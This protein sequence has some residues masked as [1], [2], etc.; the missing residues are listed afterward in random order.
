[1]KVVQSLRT[2]NFMYTP[3]IQEIFPDLDLGLHNSGINVLFA[4]PKRGRPS[5]ADIKKRKRQEMDMEYMPTNSSSKKSLRRR[6]PKRIKTG[7]GPVVDQSSSGSK[8]VLNMADIFLQARDLKTGKWK[9]LVEWDDWSLA[10]ASWTPLTY[11]SKQSSIW[12]YLLRECRYPMFNENMFP[13]LPISG[14]L[15]ITDDEEENAATVSDEERDASISDEERD[16]SSSL[17]SD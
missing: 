7:K 9:V 1:M 10:E 8:K 14:P 5:K 11:L 12:W 2:F 6:G 17:E 4:P 13:S 3:L 15:P 16:V